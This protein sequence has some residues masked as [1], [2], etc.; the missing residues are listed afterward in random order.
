MTVDLIDREATQIV[1]TFFNQSCDFFN[2]KIFV[3][4]IYTFSNGTVKMANR[5]YTS[6]AHDFSIVFEERAVIEE[7]KQD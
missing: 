3:G 6:V 1:A 7:I 5:K 2:S 4:K